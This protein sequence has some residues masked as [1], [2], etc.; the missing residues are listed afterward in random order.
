MRKTLD[1]VKNENHKLSQ[2][3]IGEQ[4]S[5]EKIEK[6]LRGSFWV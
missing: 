4:V 6:H 3:V 2:N 1:E 5:K